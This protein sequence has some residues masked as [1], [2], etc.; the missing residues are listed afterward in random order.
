VSGNVESVL[1]SLTRAPFVKK[2]KDSATPRRNLNSIPVV[3]SEQWRQIEREKQQQK[4][5]QEKLKEDR[6]K[7]RLEK[8]RNKKRGMKDEECSSDVDDPDPVPLLKKRKQCTT[9]KDTAKKYRRKQ[10]AQI[11]STNNM[12]TNDWVVV[13]YNNLQY[14]GIVTAIDEV[15]NEFEVKTMEPFTYKRQKL[16]RWPN[17]EDKIFYPAKKV[18]KYSLVPEEIKDKGRGAGLFRFFF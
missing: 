13:Q 18:R 2:K 17:H 4:E 16:W 9:K 14:P 12:K 8:Q 7:A 15:E 11:S 6:R 3:T 10:T 1:N 5:E